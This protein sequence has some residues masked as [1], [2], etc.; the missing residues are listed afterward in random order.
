[1]KLH[2]IGEIVEVNGH[3]GTIESIKFEEGETIY[4]VKFIN[5]NLCPP[6]M[7]IP[8]SYVGGSQQGNPNKCPVCKT[9]WT[10]TKFNNKEW[11]DCVKCNLTDAQARDQAEILKKNEKKKEELPSTPDYDTSWGVF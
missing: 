5:T 11:K 6:V 10:I 2:Q 4:E 7:D 1:M 8:A 9:D 3:A